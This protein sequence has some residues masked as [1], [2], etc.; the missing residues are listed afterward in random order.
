MFPSNKYLKLFLRG[1]CA[2]KTLLQLPSNML[3]DSIIEYRT[4]KYNGGHFDFDHLNLKIQLGKDFV[5]FSTPE[6]G[7]KTCFPTFPQKCQQQC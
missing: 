7:L 5:E 1:P 4:L 2:K 6:I 3:W